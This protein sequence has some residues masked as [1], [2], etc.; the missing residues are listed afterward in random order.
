MERD[1][2]TIA[3]RLK[4]A[5]ARSGWSRETLAHHA[6]VS[7]SAIT[8]IESG[9]R[10]NAR[11]G[12]LTAM[13]RALDVTVDYLV[14]E[15]PGRNLLRHRALIYGSE[16]EFVAGVAPFLRGSVARGEPVLVV[17][18]AHHVDLLKH[19]LGRD[20]RSIRFEDMQGWYAGSPLD[21]IA[22]F[23]SFVRERLDAGADWVGIV[24]HPIW[25]GRSEDEI[26]SWA[27]FESL[28]NL[29]FASW[30]L[31]AVCSYDARSPDG[32]NVEI[33]ERTHPYLAAGDEVTPSGAYE[34]PEEFVL[35]SRGEGT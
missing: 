17:A 22:G 12:T 2:S 25:A 15:D 26:R 14:G 1:A 8:Q 18:S 28:F 7:W 27:V 24:G 16:E 4:A 30:P 34:D 20:A 13:A 10:Q 33:A 19:M 23:R 9:R 32:S 35:A 6:A 5:R 31:T 21:V 11:P 3:D 29:I